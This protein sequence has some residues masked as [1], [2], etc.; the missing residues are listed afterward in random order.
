MNKSKA[1]GKLHQPSSR[2]SSNQNHKR[3]K[4]RSM[5]ALFL[6]YI[7]I[8]FDMQWVWGVLFL[9]WVIP[10][11]RNGVTYFLEPVERQSNPFEFWA[12]VG[13]WIL[14]SVF[15]ISTIFIY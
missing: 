12:I 1:L 8:F 3:F 7:V 14:M 2:N 6:M 5:S 9:F 4:W 10:D 15:S 13:S 11:I